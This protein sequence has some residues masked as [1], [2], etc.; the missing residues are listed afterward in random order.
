MLA[1]QKAG[2]YSTKYRFTG[3]EV[4]EETGLYYFGARYY[5]PRISLWYGVDPMA[6]KY[7]GNSPFCYTLN[8]P[9]ILIDPTGGFALP[10]HKS[11]TR[12][13][14]AA[15]NISKSDLNSIVRANARTDT[16]NFNKDMH[17]DNRKGYSELNTSYNAIS[18]NINAGSSNKDVGQAL[19]TTQD[20]YSHSNYTEMYLEYYTSTGGDASK[21]G[22]GDIPLFEDASSDFKSFL[23]NKGDA[24]RT[25]EFKDSQ[26]SH[27]MEKFGL[28]KEDDT[29]NP[30]HHDNMAKD[31]ENSKQGFKKLFGSKNT[32]FQYARNLAE[33]ATSKILEKKYDKKEE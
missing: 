14:A 4:D 27:V 9:I 28:K 15:F 30:F 1:E 24:F 29:D 12:T 32:N 18:A 10:V 11:I 23:E 8:N 2:G 31:S 3:K 25:G 7:P 33:R 17:F 21:L 26:L 22:V 6:E 19:H 5:D 16:K 13:I 20:F